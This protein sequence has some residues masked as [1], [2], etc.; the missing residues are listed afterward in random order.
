MSRRIGSTV[1]ALVAGLVVTALACIAA[2]AALAAAP[3]A[4]AMNGVSHTETS[5]FVHGVLSPN[6]PG[7]EG[8]YEF[9]YAASPTVCTGEDRTQRGLAF[10]YQGEGVEAEI[11]GLAPHTT[12]TVCLLDR[13]LAGEVTLSAPETFTTSLQLEVPETG[14]AEQVTSSTAVL[15]GILNPTG[16]R[17]EEP[18]FYE[19]LYKRSPNNCEGEGSTEKLP[20][21]PAALL[22]EQKEAVQA[23]VI[24]L[25]PNASYSFC[26][27]AWNATGQY[28][29]GPPVTFRT[30]SRGPA[31]S[32]E[33]VASVGSTTATVSALLDAGG[34]ET[35]Y[36]AEYGATSGYGSQANGTP[37]LIEGTRTVT[38]ELT[39]LQP[40]TEY[41]FR[42]TATN[43]E[44]AAQGGDLAFETRSPGLGALSDGRTWELVSPPEDHD[45]Q[46]YVP[47]PVYFDFYTG[48]PFQASTDGNAVVYESDVTTGGFGVSGQFSGNAQLSTRSPDGGWTQTPIQPSAFALGLRGFYEAFSPDLS[49]GIFE[50]LALP[51]LAP[52][53]PSV[54]LSER[55]GYNVLYQHDN[56]SGA[57]SSLI[58]MTPPN[59][60]P[61]RVN[62]EVIPGYKRLGT[63]NVDPNLEGVVEGKYLVYAGASA[64]FDRL[65]FEADDSLLEGAGTLA[66]ELN[67]DVKREVEE[68]RD[69]NELYVSNNGHTEL[70]NV[71]PDGNADPNATFGAQQGQLPNFSRVISDDG[72]LIFW[73][74]LNTGIVY[75]RENG[76]RT[77]PVSEG[78][79]TY[80]TASSDGSYAFYIEGEKI[81]RFN[82]ESESREQIAGAGAGAQ[83]AVGA[84]EDGS[85]LYFVA[86]GALVSGATAGQ[87][88]LYEWHGGATSLVA[89]LGAEDSQ[90]WTTDMGNRD[91]E[92]TPDGRSVTFMSGQNLSGYATEGQ[93]EVYVYES[94]AGGLFCAS[95]SPTHTPGA[96]GFLGVSNN[97]TYMPRS[98]S[99]DGGRVFFDS[100]ASLLPQDTD[101]ADDVYEWERNGIGSCAQS[102]GCLY[103]LSGGAG[104]SAF[105]DASESGNDVFFVTDTA[106][107]PADPDEMVDLYDAHVG[108]PVA[109][110]LCSGTGCQGPPAPPPTFATPASVTFAGVGNFQ[111]SPTKASAGKSSA[112]KSPSSSQARLRK[113][114]KACRA[115]RNRKVVKSCEAQARKR[116]GK[117]ATRSVLARRRG[118]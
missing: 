86:T 52:N 80:L 28:E 115:K 27:R 43:A 29:T 118:R 110:T 91:A 78:S 48:R 97:N 11:T 70:V 88:N 7:Q 109:P 22:G 35:S 14:V 36:G 34:L 90:D 31:L 99:A 19:F 53:A 6:G 32:E 71:L 102:G 83:G 59:R 41:H 74:D 72:E 1:R 58:T 42:F 60:G 116:Y 113:A 73:T 87:P 92:T 64:D 45:A 10:G 56:L 54:P 21:A 9:V 76:N 61:Y 15:H 114:L 106:L 8:T 96:S 25:A 93:Q 30:L 16:S 100:Y 117:A 79:A 40:D 95:C 46:V 2:T 4:P 51:V 75:V 3:E 77:V 101:G 55:L 105:V 50:T 85:R 81:Y 38:L 89:T 82:V 49:K 98:I 107:I 20:A 18:G 103:L 23:E 17:K 26:L 5:A 66:Q 94:E 24:N 112:R 84:S 44:G 65:L 69:T 111:P 13:N 47:E 63:P 33:S 12:Y 37:P 57:W 67:D 68:E 108:L 104:N 39:G 62:G